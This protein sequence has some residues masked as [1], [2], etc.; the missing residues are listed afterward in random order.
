MSEHFIEIRQGRKSLGLHYMTK[1]DP[2]PRMLGRFSEFSAKI[3]QKTGPVAKVGLVLALVALGAM[4]FIVYSLKSDKARAEREL[5][6]VAPGSRS[7][8]AAKPSAADEG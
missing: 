1:S 2:N 7:T 4:G 6:A 3:C 5:Q 8:E